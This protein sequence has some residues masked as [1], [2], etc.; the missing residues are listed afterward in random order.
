MPHYYI[1]R[2]L[3]LCE[4]PRRDGH[5]SGY[6]LCIEYYMKHRYV[7]GERSCCLIADSSIGMCVIVIDE[8]GDKC[9]SGVGS[10]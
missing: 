8:K 5:Q 7:G 6:E 3:G 4:C 2:A 10:V 9:V 1:Q